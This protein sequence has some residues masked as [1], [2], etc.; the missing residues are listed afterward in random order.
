MKHWNEQSL[1]GKLLGNLKSFCLGHNSKTV[2]N[3]VSHKKKISRNIKY[4][5]SLKFKQHI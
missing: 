2:T 1:T 4:E 3:V 5:K